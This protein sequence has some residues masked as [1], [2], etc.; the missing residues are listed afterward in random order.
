MSA[1]FR[2]VAYAAWVLAFGLSVWLAIEFHE[3]K[4]GIS[5]GVTVLALILSA[6]GLVLA[7][8]NAQQKDGLGT[9]IGIVLWAAGAVSF[10]ITEMGYWA[11]SYKDR[12]A[13]YVHVKTAKARQEGLTDIAWEAVKTGEVRAT[14]AEV[15]AR[16][17][18][19][20][21]SDL[22]ASSN[23]CTNAT[24]PRSRAFCQGYFELEAKLA[25]ASKLETMEAR[26]LSEKTEAKETMIHNVFAAAD[27][28]AENSKLDEKEA[29]T[30]VVLIIALVLMLSR[31]LLL[32]VANPFGGAAGARTAALAPEATVTPSASLPAIPR[33]RK[34]ALATIAGV[35]VRKDIGQTYGIAAEVSDKADVRPA[36]HS[37][38]FVSPNID[39]DGPGTPANLPKISDSS[40]A[41]G[42]TE[43]PKVVRPEQWKQDTQSYH[44]NL[45]WRLE[46][47]KK[48]KKPDDATA[49]HWMYETTRVLDDDERILK[50]WMPSR[51]LHPGYKKWCTRLGKKPLSQRRFSTVLAGELDLPKLRGADGKRKSAVMLFP[52]ELIPATQKRTRAA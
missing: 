45:D 31:D 11:S 29:A 2:T 7:R 42:D 21:Q 13:E 30:L 9:S 16:I 15:T 1:V 14:A 23:G 44:A 38:K 52:L 51:D 17:R 26:F 19:A 40:P 39:P 20:Q 6:L 25:A 10:G 18:A 3:Y 8:W 49:L 24:A 34:D 4:F 22:W 12:H 43:D 41:D 46:K 32:I 36:E 5:L 50:R 33:P 37:E 48:H 35:D 47:A 28:I 27:L